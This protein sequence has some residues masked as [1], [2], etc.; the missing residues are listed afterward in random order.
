MEEE[1]VARL[2]EYWNA[3]RR[4]IEI[5]L[6]RKKLSILVDNAEITEVTQKEA[7]EEE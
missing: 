7:A 2:R 3:Q 1:M 4:N 5:S 6:Q